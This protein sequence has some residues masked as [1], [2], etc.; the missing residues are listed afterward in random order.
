MTTSQAWETRELRIPAQ[1]SVVERRLDAVQALRDRYGTQSYF[2]GVEAYDEVLGALGMLRWEP[3]AKT[4]TLYREGLLER[5][6]SGRSN[7]Y[8]FRVRRGAEEALWT[9]INERSAN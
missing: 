7:R 6:Y 2:T 9:D 8:F 3:S 5:K 1:R 4:A